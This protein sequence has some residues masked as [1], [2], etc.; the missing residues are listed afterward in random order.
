[1]EKNHIGT[2]ALKKH[3][4]NSVKMSRKRI[5]KPITDM[6]KINS[7]QK[8]M[9]NAR[10]RQIKNQGSPMINQLAVQKPRRPAV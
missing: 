9:R 3:E 6:P 8:L 1:M 4:N 2:N 5:F 10:Q 7:K